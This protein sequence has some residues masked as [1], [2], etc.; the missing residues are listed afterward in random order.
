VNVDFPQWMVDTLDQEAQRLG[1]HRQAVIKTWIAQK[2]DHQTESARDR[3]LITRAELIAFPKLQRQKLILSAKSDS[4]LV[5][6]D[7]DHWL[8]VRHQSKE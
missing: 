5:T 6:I 1:I 7:V 2:L 3:A 8:T 4:L